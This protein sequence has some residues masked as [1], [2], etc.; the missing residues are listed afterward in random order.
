MCEPPIPYYLQAV[1]SDPDLYNPWLATGEAQLGQRSKRPLL[2]IKGVLDQMHELASLPKPTP[3]KVVVSSGGGGGGGGR[4]VKRSQQLAAAPAQAPLKEAPMFSEAQVA[5]ILAE[6]T[7]AA[8]VS[9]TNPTS[10]VKPDPF[11][12]ISKEKET[13]NLRAQC[14][15]APVSPALYPYPYPYPYP[16]LLTF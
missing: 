2:H 1:K 5:K 10:L 15:R 14:A 13:A 9:S 7:K 12:A 6:A 8:A 11:L 16:N 3:S 4:G